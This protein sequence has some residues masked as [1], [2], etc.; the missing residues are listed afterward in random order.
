M[1]ARISEN[2]WLK[3]ALTDV[4]VWS[5]IAL[6]PAMSHVLPVPIYLLEPMRLFLFLGYFLSREKG[7]GYILALTIPFV[8]VLLSGHPVPLKACLIAIELCLNVF[9]F[10]MLLSRFPRFQFVALLASILI[11]KF[12]YYGLK[13]V[14]LKYTLIDGNLMSTPL[15]YQIAA[16]LFVTIIYSLIARTRKGHS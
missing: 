1:I 9:F 12:F 11:S 10:E 15:I 2:L 6:I 14:L 5:M 3:I 8:S 4:I 16:S 7:N 13:Y